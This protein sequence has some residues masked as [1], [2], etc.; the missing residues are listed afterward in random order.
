[1]PWDGLAYFVKHSDPYTEGMSG[2]IRWAPKLPIAMIVRLYRADAEGRQDIDLLNDVGWRLL[3]RARDVLLVSD[4]Q[5]R[6]PQCSTVVA[7]PWIGRPSD[8]RVECP[9]CGWSITAGEFHATFEHQDLSGGGAREAFEEFV[10]RFPRLKS[11]SEKMIAID[12]LVNAVHTTGGVAARNLFEGR[13]RKVLATLQAI[14]QS[15]EAGPA[16]LDDVR[17]AREEAESP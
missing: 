7:V 4:S 8:D 15:R 6:C 11:Y 16:W 1:M 3:V 9:A 17:R 12:R 5:A 10:N 13:A 14:S 2:A